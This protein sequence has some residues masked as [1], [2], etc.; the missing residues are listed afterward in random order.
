[1]RL[2]KGCEASMMLEEDGGRI[3]LSQERSVI[4]VVAPFRTGTWNGGKVRRL[5]VMNGPMALACMIER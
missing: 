1:M 3:E 2:K 4:E 5:T